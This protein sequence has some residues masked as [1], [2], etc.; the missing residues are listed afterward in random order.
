MTGSEKRKYKTM[1]KRAKVHLHHGPQRQ[2]KILKSK[3]Q[4][5]RIAALAAERRAIIQGLPFYIPFRNP[6]AR[7]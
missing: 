2:T 7:S 1:T 5:E 4:E 6:D 3:H